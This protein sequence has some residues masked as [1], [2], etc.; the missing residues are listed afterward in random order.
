MRGSLRVQKSRV[1][2]AAE[3]VEM[4]RKLEAVRGTCPLEVSQSSALRA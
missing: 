2:V 4:L 3:V 1:W